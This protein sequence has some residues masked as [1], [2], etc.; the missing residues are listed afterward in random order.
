MNNERYS[1]QIKLS[2]IGVDGQSRLEAASVLVVGLGGLGAPVTTY[3][4][5]A[6]VGRIGLC[7]NDIVSLS[8][9]QRQTL[10]TEAEVGLKKTDCAARRLNALSGHTVFEKFPDGLN[11]ENAA[12]TV[13]SFD[14]VLDCCD[15]FGTRYLIDDVCAALGKTWIYASIG[16]FYGQLAVM[17]GKAG[18]RY[19]D[20]YPDRSALES[21]N[22][23]GNG[24]LGT[25][26]AVVGA[27]A[28]NEAIK[29]LAGFGEPLDGKLFSINLKTLQTN[30]INF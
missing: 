23:R 28:A 11:A 27:L 8:N 21:V 24:V 5:G 1:R 14:L 29:I 13:A 19:S 26:P 15:N 25:V 6:G 3:L 10:Y 18:I 30:I 16:A 7:D 2:E 4:T 22:A 12:A 20:L 9:L 17:N